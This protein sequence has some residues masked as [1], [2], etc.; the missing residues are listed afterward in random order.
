MRKEGKMR[1]I[2]FRGWSET[3]NMW[4]YGLLINNHNTLM[5]DIESRFVYKIVNAETI[6]QFTGLLDKNGKKVFEGDII[7]VDCS[8][9]GGAFEDGIYKVKYFLPYCAF[10][11]QQLDESNAISFNECYIYEV[12]GNIHEGGDNE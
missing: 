6:G 11:L 10:Y 12:I 3:Y 2:L 7:R 9:V 8:P 4:I 1:E 5:K